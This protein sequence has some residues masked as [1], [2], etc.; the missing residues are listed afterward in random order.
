MADCLDE[1]SQGL[2][3]LSA[4]CRV[5]SYLDDIMVFAP[6]EHAAGA[7]Q[8]VVDALTHHGLTVNESKTQAWSADRAGGLPEAVRAH[9][10]DHLKCLG[11]TAP[12]LDQQENRVL[13]HAGE[14]GAAA[15][16]RAQA[17]TQKLRDLRAKNKW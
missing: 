14:D 7:K 1:I 11:N 2:Q 17:F 10:V 12:W 4:T 8:L 16:Q 15:V 13:V 3:H 5:F 6:P 9:R